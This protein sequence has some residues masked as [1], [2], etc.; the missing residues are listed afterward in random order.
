MSFNEF[1]VN[2]LVN[3]GMFPDQALA[4]SLVLYQTYSAHPLWLTLALLIGN[5]GLTVFWVLM[6]SRK[7]N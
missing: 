6:V 1:V 4:A 2:G 5:L 3:N 7:W